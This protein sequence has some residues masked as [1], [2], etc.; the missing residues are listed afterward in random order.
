MSINKYKKKPIIIEAVQ[1]TGINLEEIKS[2][3]GD[4]LDY[5]YKTNWDSSDLSNIEVK[6][7]TLEGDHI[8]SIGDYIIKGV[9]GE[10]YPCKPDI[11][12]KTYESATLTSQNEWVS[13]EEKL[14][15]NNTQVLMWSARW[16]IAEAESYYNKHF[17]VYS[18]IGDGYIADNITH[19]MSLPEPPEKE[20]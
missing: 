19:W 18:E 5:N 16:K 20:E 14:P 1:W 6:I 11:F 8:A 13:V 7:K 12:K 3:V 4:S 17:W 15:E 10:F 2:F 9:N